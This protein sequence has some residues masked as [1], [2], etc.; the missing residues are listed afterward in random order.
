M[1]QRL[2]HRPTRI[3]E[4]LTEPEPEKLA[5]PPALPDGQLGG[6]ALHTLIPVAGALSS[7]VMIVV[8]RNN[9]P[10]YLVAGAVLLVVALVAG[11]GFA[12]TQRGQA[13]PQPPISAS[14]TWTT[15]NASGPPCGTGR[16][17]GPATGHHP[18]SRPGRAAG[19]GA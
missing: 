10:L 2:V 18:G 4:P 6:Q 8:L 15:W 12:V 9:N 17:R 14:S 3:T 5:P 1:T 19:T 11:V 16:R 13:I 7:I